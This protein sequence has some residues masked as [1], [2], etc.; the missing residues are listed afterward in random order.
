MMKTRRTARFH[1]P[2][3]LT[4]TV[5]TMVHGVAAW[6]SDA[7]S[8]DAGGVATTPDAGHPAPD[9]SYTATGSPSTPAP[10]ATVGGTTYDAG[11]FTEDTADCAGPQK[12]GLVLF[13]ASCC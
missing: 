6:A 8:P 7:G 2:V 13:G 4:F 11:R 1:T 3:T 10:T 9:P 12:N 5:V